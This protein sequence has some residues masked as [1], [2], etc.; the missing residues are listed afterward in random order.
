[1]RGDE[2]EATTGNSVTHTWARQP[3]TYTLATQVLVKGSGYPGK[4]LRTVITDSA[5][6]HNRGGSF[7]MVV[8]LA[9]A[10][11]P[12]RRPNL[13]PLSPHHGKFIAPIIDSSARSVGPQ[14]ELGRLIDTGC[15]VLTFGARLELHGFR[16]PAVVTPALTQHLIS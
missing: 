15:C 10:S 5:D 16:V 2:T 4:V 1:M 13:C 8:L 7:M 6:L 11:V 3:S 14:C 9:S 12:Y